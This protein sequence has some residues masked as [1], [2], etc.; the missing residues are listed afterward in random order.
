MIPLGLIFGAMTGCYIG[1]VKSTTAANAIYLQYTATFWVVPLGMIFLRERPD[2]RAEVGIALAMLGIA[3]IVGWGYDG[4]PEEWKGIAP[5]A[6]PAASPSPRWR[7]GCAAS[8]TS[9]RSGSAR[10]TTCSGALASGSGS[11]PWAHAITC[12]DGRVRVW[13]SLAFGTIQMA[14]PTSCSPEACARSARPRP[15]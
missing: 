6:W 3:V 9:T 5:W 11:S 4:R 13:R 2:R 1:A 14:F 7:R 12:A 10:S 15:D 8:A